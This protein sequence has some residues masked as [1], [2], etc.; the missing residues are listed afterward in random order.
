MSLVVS[1]LVDGQAPLPGGGWQCAERFQ[2]CF[3]CL[4]R[5][6]GRTA[7]VLDPLHAVLW[8]LPQHGNN[9]MVAAMGAIQERRITALPAAHVS[10]LA[11]QAQRGD[12]W[13]Y[14][15][16]APREVRER[17]ATANER[18]L[19]N[20]LLEQWGARG[21]VTAHFL[22]ARVVHSIHVHVVDPVAYGRVLVCDNLGS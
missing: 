4:V 21:I 3:V 13:L 19:L 10:L 8:A 6:G 5:A 1:E 12:H 20:V 15:G 16:E 2:I 7:V 9:E 22:V 14:V 17:V 11:V 18:G